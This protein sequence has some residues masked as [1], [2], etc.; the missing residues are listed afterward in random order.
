MAPMFGWLRAASAR[1]SRS[2]RARRSGLLLT[3]A[4][5]AEVRQSEHVQPALVCARPGRVAVGE[6]GVAAVIDKHVSRSSRHLP[7]QRSAMTVSTGERVNRTEV[8]ELT[9]RY[10]AGEGEVQ[11]G[12]G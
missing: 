2:K 5:R 10:R 1:A 12:E 6:V 9:E 11:I 7:A 3:A 4:G 8:C